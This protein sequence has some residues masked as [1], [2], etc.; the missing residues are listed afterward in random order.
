MIFY[1]TNFTHTPKPLMVFLY[2]N[3]ELVNKSPTEKCLTLSNDKNVTASAKELTQKLKP[4]ITIN[5]L[6]FS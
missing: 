2:T 6:T 1:K 5:S 3:T 4:Q